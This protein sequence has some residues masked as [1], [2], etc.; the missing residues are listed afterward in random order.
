MADKEVK[1]EE[2]TVTPNWEG[3]EQTSAQMMVDPIAYR[4]DY[5]PADIRQ[6]DWTDGKGNI[7]VWPQ[8]ANLNYF[9]YGDDSNPN[10]QSQKGWMNDKYTGEW[11]SNT[12]LD[13]DP[14]IKTS[15]LDPNYLY[16]ENARQQNR[17]EAWYIAR[18]NDM[19]AS[20]LYNEWR[21]SKEDVA[22]F[23]SQQNEWMNSTEAD[24]LNTIE[25]VWKR[26][27]QIN[28]QEKPDIS[29][30]E[31]DL[32]KSTAWK[33]YWKTT[34]EEWEPTGWINTLEDENSVYKAMTAARV[35]NMKWLLAMDPASIAAS[36]I[37]GITPY[38][39]QAMR[40]LQQYYPDVYQQVQAEQKKLL[41][42]E[43]TTAIATW[44]EIST[45]ADKV[46]TDTELTSYAV[47]NSTDSTSATQLLKWIDS[48]LESNDTAKSAQELMWS[49]ENDMAKLKNRL[50]NLKK[51][52][53]TVFKW[54]V[55]DYIVKAYMANKTQEIQDN[56]SVLED[57]YNA[58]Y[59]RYKQEVANAQWEK[60]YELKKEQLQIQRDAQTLD[61]WKAKNWVTWWTTK[62]QAKM[63]T[64]RNNNPTAMTTDVAKMLGWELWVD[65]EIWDSFITAS[66]QTLY[67]AKLIWDPVETTIRLIDRWIANGI[68]PFY[69]ANWQPRWSYISSIWITKDK[70]VKMSPSEKADVI[71]Q[72][73]KHEWWSMENMLYYVEQNK[74]NS[75]NG[76][77][78]M[79]YQSSYDKYL[80][81]DYSK[82]WLE[83]QAAAMWTTIQDFDA[84][85]RAWKR[86]LDAWLLD[87]DDEIL[88]NWWIWTR[89]DW[90]EYDF[91]KSQLYRTLSLKDKLAVQALL[92]NERGLTY[93][94]A[95]RSK[96]DDPASIMSAVTEIEPSWSEDWFKQRDKAVG[97]RTQWEQ[98]GWI[99]K[100]ASAMTAAMQIYY[101]TDKIPDTT[102][103]WLKSKWIDNIEALKD[104]N[105]SLLEQSWNT[106]VVELA[107][108][109]KWLQ[110]EA[111]GALKWWNA[112][113][114]DE[115]SREMQRILNTWLSQRQMR[116]AMISMAKLLYWKD[117]SE[118]R[119]VAEWTFL[120]PKSTW[121]D[122]ASDWMYN[123]AWIDLTKYYSYVPKW[124]K[125]PKDSSTWWSTSWSW[126]TTSGSSGSKFNLNNLFGWK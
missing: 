6:Y 45:S 89:L 42:Q 43:N 40:D 27:G 112:A 108:L 41:T 116:T 32:N 120:K 5:N 57:R 46:D 4:S 13:Y 117:E 36:M 34:A 122:D 14:N 2:T 28:P 54:D 59:N 102:W 30:M 55:P 51:E 7:T 78:D 103:K 69:R 85:A 126:T 38:G 86:D 73:L 118:V 24:R 3:I 71:N 16:W 106:D 101:M 90:K 82:A 20:A 88:A 97:K 94:N 92:N 74:G 121:T 67:T 31:E 114:S 66:W 49:I 63:R 98:W 81:W 18:R 12:Y 62:W 107:V 84:Q 119:D 44:W 104:V 93:I 50:K 48:I 61:E 10:Q 47:N 19:I 75:W 39:D 8:N 26:L 25:S 29:V 91:S 58:A 109:L 23:L 111:A 99:S 115:D 113:I 15:D 72:M 64:E 56:L 65:Y 22:D 76:E 53:N 123:V 21:V 110:S 95:N 11:V 1:V 125:A 100:N 83:A 17:K 52:A 79:T 96:Y 9:Q 77:Y 35:A 60:E 87:V 80:S 37:S 105:I 68:D 33:I 70:W 124:W